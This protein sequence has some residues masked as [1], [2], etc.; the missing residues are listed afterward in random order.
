MRSVVCV[1]LAIYF[2]D[3]CYRMSPKNIDEVGSWFL[4]FKGLLFFVSVFFAVLSLF[5]L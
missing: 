2:S 1:L 3:V 5:L 4:L